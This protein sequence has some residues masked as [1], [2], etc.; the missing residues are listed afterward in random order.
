[1]QERR[2][3]FEQQ[4]EQ[5]LGQLYRIARRL[6]REPADAEDL[7]H[8]TYVKAFKAIS[9]TELEDEQ[10]CR[11]WLYRILI[12]AF[13]DRCRHDR[14][15]PEVSG[16]SII[17]DQTADTTLTAVSETVDPETEA[18]GGEFVADAQNAILALPADL[19]TVVV[20]FFI[21]GLSHKEIADVV[22]IP[23]GTAMTRLS[24]GRRL[25]QQSLAHHRQ[26]SAERQVPS[27]ENRRGV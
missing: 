2:E 1:M 8:D 13:R 14:R 5:Y 23:P 26:A 25:L 18:A 9:R 4:T 24:R 11:R 19:R 6:V 10:A 7:V 12:N 17:D 27:G 20:L 3:S 16:L 22:A 21:E 15:S